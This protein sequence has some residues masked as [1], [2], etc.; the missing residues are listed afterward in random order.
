MQR[1]PAIIVVAVFYNMHMFVVCVNGA[2]MHTQGCTVYIDIQNTYMCV[3]IY[4]VCMYVC[5]CTYMHLYTHSLHMCWYTFP[6]HEV[7]SE[8]RKFPVKQTGGR[9]MDRGVGV[10]VGP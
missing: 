8:P 4:I 7:W 5:I 10:G 2:C 3:Y 1:K 6:F 9:A